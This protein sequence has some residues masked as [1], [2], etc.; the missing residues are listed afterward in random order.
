[1]FIIVFSFVTLFVTGIF[2][3]NNNLF[4]DILSHLP[5]T[6]NDKIKRSSITKRMLYHTAPIIIASLLFVTLLGYVKVANEKG[7]SYF[8]TY[9]KSLHYYCTYNKIYK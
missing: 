4:K 9:N 2:I 7:N 6:N 3:Y 5:V 8:E 1:M